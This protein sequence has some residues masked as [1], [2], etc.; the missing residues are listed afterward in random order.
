MHDP[1]KFWDSLAVSRR[2]AKVQAAVG[3]SDELF[4]VTEPSRPATVGDLNSSTTKYLAWLALCG[5][6]SA[7][8]VTTV[9]VH[10]AAFKGGDRAG[11]R[12]PDRVMV[13]LFTD[14]AH[15]DGRQLQVWYQDGG[16]RSALART[17]PGP[18]SKIDKV[19]GLLAFMSGEVGE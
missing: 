3:D 11:E 14:A 18:W 8:Q 9:Y 16:M 7:S 19:S 1:R 15:E 10:G 13:N 17:G 4:E 12:R 6:W 2:N 5:F